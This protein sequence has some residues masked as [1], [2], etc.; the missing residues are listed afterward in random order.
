MNGNFDIFDAIVI[1]GVIQGIAATIAV[2][3][4]PSNASGRKLLSALLLTLAFLSI[5]ILLHTSGLWQHSGFRYFPLAI[6]T[7]IQPLFY[8]YTCSLTEKDFSLRRRQLWHFAPAALFQIHAI[9]VYIIT[10]SQPDIHTKDLIAEKELH[11][12]A[13][14][15]TEDMFALFSAV[16]YWFLSFRRTQAYRKWLFTSQSATQ[17]SEFAWLRNLL[18]GTGIL[19]VVLFLSSLSSNIL[20]LKNTF[21]Y[22]EVFYIYLTLLIYFL[23]FQGYRALIAGETHIL[24]SSGDTSSLVQVIPKDLSDVEIKTTEDK[25]NFSA[26]QSALEEIM[27]KELLFLE[28]ELNI[29]QIAIATGFPSAQVSAAIN[30]Q[31]RVNFRSWV[32]GYRVEEVKKRLADPAYKHLSLLGIAFD[33]GFNS[34]ASFYRIFKNHTGHSPKTY[35][36]NIK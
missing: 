17:Y 8:L 33:C 5:K 27:N 30:A 15:W 22:L 3:C 21:F 19:V 34:E 36:Q 23:S 7:L 28:P 25:E 29:K 10:M 16:M 6:D 1:A 2:W 26:I 24:R 13:V 18:I 31:F 11:Y 32:N 14:K 12:N 35:L 20:Q 9:I 4:Y